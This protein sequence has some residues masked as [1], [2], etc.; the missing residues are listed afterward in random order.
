[1]LQEVYNFYRNDMKK[2]TEKYKEDLQI[3]LYLVDLLSFLKTCRLIYRNTHGDYIYFTK[4]IFQVHL[5]GFL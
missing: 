3:W 1:M 4:H 2:T 5:T